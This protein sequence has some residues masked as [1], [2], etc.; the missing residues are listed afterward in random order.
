MKR[1]LKIVVVI[2]TL[3]AVAVVGWYAFV[4][5]VVTDKPFYDSAFDQRTWHKNYDN[6]APDNPRAEMVGDLIGNYLKPGMTRREVMQ[7]LGKPDRRDERRFISY[8]IGMQGF[9]SD[10]GQLEIEFSDEKKVVKYYL[11]ER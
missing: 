3:C 8:L 5:I 7:L 11:V 4:F 6:P 10:P 9:A 1:T 2:G